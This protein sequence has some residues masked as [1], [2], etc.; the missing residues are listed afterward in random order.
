MDLTGTDYPVLAP[1]PKASG[2]ILIA[3]IAS[4]FLRIIGTD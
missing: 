1:P 3:T 2:I 4:E